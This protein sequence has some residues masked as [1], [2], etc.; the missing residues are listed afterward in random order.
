M[1]SQITF[2]KKKE[3]GAARRTSKPCKPRPLIYEFDPF[4]ALII[5]Y[6]ACRSSIKG[7]ERMHSAQTEARLL[8][9]TVD[10]ML[11]KINKRKEDDDRWR[12]ENGT[13]YPSRCTT[14]CFIF[15]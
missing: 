5:A 13:W 7:V 3:Q 6:T 4:S 14:W 8:R 10:E 9:H 11:E 12:G 1:S 2:F 15:T